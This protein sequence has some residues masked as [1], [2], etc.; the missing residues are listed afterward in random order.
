M[1]DIL[2]KVLSN[3]GPLPAGLNNLSEENLKNLPKELV[4]QLLS[5]ARNTKDDF[6]NALAKGISDYLQKLDLDKEIAKILDNYELDFQIN[7]KFKK[8]SKE[9]LSKVEEAGIASGTVKDEE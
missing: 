2:K 4:N 7:L 6:M 1:S 3:L 8:R 5:N 9:S